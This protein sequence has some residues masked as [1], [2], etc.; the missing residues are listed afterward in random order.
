MDTI[1][2]LIA[3]CLV[4]LLAVVASRRDRQR[5]NAQYQG[6]IDQYLKAGEL[7]HDHI[8]DHVIRDKDITWAKSCAP[9]VTFGIKADGSLMTSEEIEEARKSALAN[10][11]DGGQ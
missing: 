7:L 1:L 5:I 6:F 10:S 2:F 11:E 4:G 8:R 3:L 9:V